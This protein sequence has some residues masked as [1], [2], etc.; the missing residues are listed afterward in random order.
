MGDVSR[1]SETRVLLSV[2]YELSRRSTCSRGHNGAV[3]AQHGRIIASGYNGAVSGRPHCDHRCTCSADAEYMH[4]ENCAANINSGCRD[5]V[6]AEANAIAFA[7]RAGVS[8]QNASIYCTT[9]P[10]Y[11]CAKLII[12][13]GIST[14]AYL[15]SYRLTNG[16]DLLSSTKGVLVIRPP[17]YPRES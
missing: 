2:A 17:V 8:T 10:C 15:L 9:A 3:I 11:D 6:H 5:S 1:P 4:S 16:L 7:A 14:V 13:S 12:N